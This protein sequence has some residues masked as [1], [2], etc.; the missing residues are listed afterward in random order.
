MDVVAVDHHVAQVDAHAEG[1]AVAVGLAGDVRSDGL[2][3]FH[4]GGHGVDGAR[5]LDEHAITH[6]LDDP[7]VVPGEPGVDELGA[8]RLEGDERA[9]L[10][11]PD[12][13]RIADHVGGQYCGETALHRLPPR[14]V[15]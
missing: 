6:E 3:R 5:E 14:P 11:G 12:Q 2:L 9:L 7:A 1:D 10:V 15:D 4:G 8:K 13:A